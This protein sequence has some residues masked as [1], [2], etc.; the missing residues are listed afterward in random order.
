METISE[1]KSKLAEL[2][3]IVEILAELRKIANKLDEAANDLAGLAGHEEAWPLEEGAEEVARPS[4]VTLAE[5]EF[6]LIE[7]EQLVPEAAYRKNGSDGQLAPL[8]EPISESSAGLVVEQTVE[9]SPPDIRQTP[10]GVSPSAVLA[11]PRQIERRTEPSD[12]EIR[13]RAYFLSERRRSFAL[14]GDSDSDW[15]E[16]KRQLLCESGELGGLSTIT[17]GESGRILRAVEDVALSVTVAS[18]KPRVESIEQEKGMPYETT[19]TEIQS[20]AAEAIPEPASNSPNAV[21][22]EPVFPQTTTLPTMLNSRQIQTAPVDKSPSAVMAKTPPPTGPAGT[23]VDVTFSFEITAVQLTPTFEMG[24]LTV[25]PASRLVTMRLALHLHSQPTENLQ[26]SF[27]AAKIQPAGGTLGT[28]WM[29][30]SK[31]QR[32]VANG[33]RSFAPA[34]LQVV[35]NFE[36]APVQLTPSQPA[37]ATVLVTVPCEINIVEL[38]PLFEIASVI[39]NSSCKRVFVQLPGTRPRGEE[40]VRVFEIAN[41]EL[42]ESGEISTMQLNLLGPADA[43]LT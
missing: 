5:P 27:E 14:R 8:A 38:S 30:P 3:K 4:V 33:S 13:L 19:S 15:H 22:A 37:Q 29:L 20:S 11:M 17:A 35:P 7:E 18:A 43:S 34:E 28:L 24:A 21:S 25:R 10:N 2:H 41:L 42:T 31:Q 40:T 12:Q 39:L 32:P 36:A 9:S 16:A 26:V 23:S 1:R 6:G